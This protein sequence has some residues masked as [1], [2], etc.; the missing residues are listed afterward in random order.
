MEIQAHPFQPRDLVG[1]H[2]VLDLVNTV[3][4]RNARPVDWLDSYGRLLD[5][6]HLSGSFDDD[7]LHALE[8]MSS[9]DQTGA[10]AA[11]DRVRELRELLVET[12]MSTI[13]RPDS[14]PDHMSRL[15]AE[16]KSA[17]A[18]AWLVDDAGRV[19]LK[20]SVVRS[21]LDYL[22]H[23]LALRAVDLLEAL[24]LERTRLCPGSHCGW[25]FID[26]SRGG[27]RRWCDMATCG[28][29]AKGRRHYE[30]SRAAAR[31]SG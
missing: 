5:W 9:T 14:A 16:W 20:L 6:A 29:A 1:G 22:R 10:E 19:R 26:R 30:R 15:E 7:T 13:Q 18:H 2:V 4:A 31:P 25:L 24:P 11:L 27:G 17:V 23:D 12:F 21:G 28:N 8:Q 3:T